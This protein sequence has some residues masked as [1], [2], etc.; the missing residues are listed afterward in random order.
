MT[1]TSVEIPLRCSVSTVAASLLLNMITWYSVVWVPRQFP[2]STHPLQ[3]HILEF[4]QKESPLVQQLKPA[5]GHPLHRNNPKYFYQKLHRKHLPS[6]FT[7]VGFSL[8]LNPC[9]SWF[10]A[11][12]W[13]YIGSTKALFDIHWQLDNMAFWQTCGLC[14][15]HWSSESLPKLAVIHN[16]KNWS[17]LI[18]VHSILELVWDRLVSLMMGYAGLHLI[19]L[20]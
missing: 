18:H 10:C 20:I 17:K 9:K 16:V 4:L 19:K 7:D 11:L 1:P 3:A 5:R 15:L 8:I 13:P 14:I 6:M 12:F 2:R